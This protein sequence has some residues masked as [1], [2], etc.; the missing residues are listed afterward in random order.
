MPVQAGPASGNTHSLAAS[1]QA[2]ST[3]SPTA[4]WS[5]WLTGPSSPQVRSKLIV[6]TTSGCS[7]RN[8]AARSRRSAIPYSTSPS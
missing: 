5:A 3:A 4:R 8:A 7:L 6:M 1:R 2:S